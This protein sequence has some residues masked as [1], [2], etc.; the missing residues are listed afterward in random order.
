MIQLNWPCSRR[1]GNRGGDDEKEP[2]ISWAVPMWQALRQAHH[3]DSF[4]FHTTPWGIHGDCLH[5]VDEET[6]GEVT[7]AQGLRIGK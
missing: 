6:K 2:T 3:M 5:F 4:N 1:G 7:V